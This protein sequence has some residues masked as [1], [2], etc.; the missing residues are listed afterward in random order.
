MAWLYLALAIGFEVAGTTALKMS[1][2]FAHLG[3]GAAALASYG[4]ALV[5]LALALKAIPVGIAYAVWSGVGV[6]A[7]TVIG[8][9]AFGQRLEA[10]AL[11][12]IG[13][14]VAGVLTLNLVAGGSGR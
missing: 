8:W 13:L 6:A 11:I 3:A 10:P 9:T 5:F 7:I 14:I 4:V 12:G 1:D 2:G